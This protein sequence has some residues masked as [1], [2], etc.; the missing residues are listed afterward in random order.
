MTQ[1]QWG[2][3]H[4]QKKNEESK[5]NLFKKQEKNVTKSVNKRP[6]INCIKHR[7]SAL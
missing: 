3:R 4:K 7:C 1:T 5:K 6:N 2:R